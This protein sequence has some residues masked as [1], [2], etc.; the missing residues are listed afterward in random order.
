MAAAPTADRIATAARRLLER[1]GAAAVTMR[2]VAD[3]VGITAMAIYRHYPDR[4]ALLEALAN[5]GFAELAGAF[6]GKR[7]PAEVEAR[8]VRLVDIYVEYALDNPRLFELMFLAPRRGAR[9]FPRDFKAGRSPTGNVVAAAI[10][11]GM[12][13]GALRKDDPWEIAFEL[14]ALVD[15]LLVLYLGGRIEG[16]PARFRA[17]LRRSL[18]RYLHGICC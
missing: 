12:A 5:R 17:L 4:D 3:A 7:P 8:L 18:R 14:G 6:G 15:G 11:D 13:R 10:E 1:E 9:R 16:G 2:Q